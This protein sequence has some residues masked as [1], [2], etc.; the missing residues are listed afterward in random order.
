[1]RAVSLTTDTSILAS[2]GNDYRYSVFF[3]RQI[4]A[5]AILGDLLIGISTSGASENVLNVFDASR[6]RSVNVIGLLGKGGGEIGKATELAVVIPS[7]ITAHIQEA[8]FFI[9]HVWCDMI[10]T[11]LLEKE[12][13]NLPR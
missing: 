3:A 2:P 4:E 6:S 12:N 13:Y 5:I 1:M 11:R 9:L 8:H 10:E 7:D